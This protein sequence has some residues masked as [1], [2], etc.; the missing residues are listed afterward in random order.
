MSQGKDLLK[1]ERST[2]FWLNNFDV[3]IF[4]DGELGEWGETGGKGEGPDLRG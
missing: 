4:S 1:C 2:E 3:Q